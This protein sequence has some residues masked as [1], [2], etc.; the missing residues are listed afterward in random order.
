MV[1]LKARD[2]FLLLAA[3][4]RRLRQQALRRLRSCFLSM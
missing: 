4:M 3:K 1:E 2:V